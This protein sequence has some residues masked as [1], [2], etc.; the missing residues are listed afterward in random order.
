MIKIGIFGGSFDP[1]HRSH[2]RVIEE[3]LRQL[4]LDKILVI[5]TANNPWKDSVGAT[6]EQRLKM[7]EIALHRYRNVEICRYEIDQDGNDKKYTIDTINYLKTIYPKEQLYFIM[8]MDQASLFHK[9]KDAKKISE[10]VSL[11]VFERVGYQINENLNRFNFI[12]L[13][14]IASDDASSDIRSGKLHALLP[15]VLK[16]IVINGIYLETIVKT[17]MSNKRYLHTISMASLAKE[18]AK[19]NGLN[20]TK[21]YVAGMLHDIA[22]EMPH[23]QALSLMNQYFPNYIDKP[24]AI[25]HQW[26]SAHLA[27]TEYLVDDPEILQAIRHHTTASINMSKLDMC[28]YEADKYDPS[29]DFD[30]SKEIAVCKSDVVAGFKLCLKDF[31][32]FSMKKNRKIDNCFF[33]IYN[34]YVKGDINE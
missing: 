29:R 21:A 19:S 14:L 12:K 16:Y 11:V 33:E 1:I 17:K 13:E 22:K 20:E 8:G 18:I 30:S 5:P 28:I 15:E 26:L 3:A 4:Q 23:D 32:D 9:W 6:K 2:I 25:W 34:R 10:L 27:K 31:Y 24:E 7:L